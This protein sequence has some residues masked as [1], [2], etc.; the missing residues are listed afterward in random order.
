MEHAQ[1][2]DRGQALANEE[3]STPA[4][5]VSDAALGKQASQPLS[6]GTAT[7]RAPLGPPEAA[8]RALADSVVHEDYSGTALAAPLMLALHEFVDSQGSNLRRQQTILLLSD[9]L[10]E[11]LRLP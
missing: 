10:A 3:D 2:I 9:V 11:P 4:M 1:F 5:E 7:V 6:A 8:L